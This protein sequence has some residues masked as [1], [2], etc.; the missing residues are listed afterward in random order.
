MVFWTIGTPVETVKG[1]ASVWQCASGSQNGV[2]FL[3][4]VPLA[5]KTFDAILTW[6]N[7]GAGA[8]DVDWRLEDNPVTPGTGLGAGVTTTNVT[9][10]AGVQGNTVEMTLRAGI[11]AVAAHRLW[12]FRVSNLGTG[13]LGNAADIVDLILERVT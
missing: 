1:I 4:E 5:W 9:D 6:T 2:T 12:L 3:A 7:D 8:G 11:T 13:T 10:T